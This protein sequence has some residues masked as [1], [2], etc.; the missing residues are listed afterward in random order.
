M[1]AIFSMTLVF[2]ETQ[3]DLFIFARLLQIL[4]VTLM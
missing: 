1:R 3:L 4:M 2:L